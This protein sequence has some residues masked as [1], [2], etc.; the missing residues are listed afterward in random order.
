V[1]IGFLIFFNK[2]RELNKKFIDS[3]MMGRRGRRAVSINDTNMGTWE[4]KVK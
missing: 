2:R 3:V 1:N 4:V